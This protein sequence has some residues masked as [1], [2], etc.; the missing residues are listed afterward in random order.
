MVSRLRGG[1]APHPS[2]FTR[3]PPG[4]TLEVT[5]WWKE[6]NHIICKEAQK[7]SWGSSSFL[8]TNLTK[9]PKAAVNYVDHSLVNS[10]PHEREHT[11]FSTLFVVEMLLK[12]K[13]SSLTGLNLSC[14]VRMSKCVLISPI[15]TNVGSLFE[16]GPITSVL[17]GLEPESLHGLAG[18]RQHNKVN[19]VTLFFSLDC[20]SCGFWVQIVHLY[21]FC[22][23]DFS[24][25]L[26]GRLF[27][28]DTKQ[29]K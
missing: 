21:C 24:G 1:A 26:W 4:C 28:S 3:K 27:K 15:T 18:L 23:H 2:C 7:K 12:Q 19:V 22:T 5:D 13:C 9:T 29:V 10:F 17:L 8:G 20:D 11:P 14:S 16:M 6:Q 25:T